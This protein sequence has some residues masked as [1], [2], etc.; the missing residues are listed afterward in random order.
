MDK[1]F[2]IILGILMGLLILTVN[3]FNFYSTE[4]QS[5]ENQSEENQS[6]KRNNNAVNFLRKCGISKR[7][8]KRMKGM[9]GKGLRSLSHPTGTTKQEILNCFDTNFFYMV[10]HNLCYEMNNN[11]ESEFNDNEQF[12]RIF[13]HKTSYGIMNA[14]SKNKRLW[15]IMVSYNFPNMINYL[16]YYSKSKMELNTDM[17]MGQYLT[18]QE[19]KVNTQSFW[20]DEY[21]KYKDMDL[22]LYHKE[23]Q[24]CSDKD[25]DF[26][27]FFYRYLLIKILESMK[28]NLSSR[29]NKDAVSFYMQRENTFNVTSMIL[30][31]NKN[32]EL[33]RMATYYRLP[34]VC[35]VWVIYNLYKNSINMSVD[36]DLGKA[37]LTEKQKTL[38]GKFD[39]DYVEFYVDRYANGDAE[40]VFNNID[41]WKELD[42]NKF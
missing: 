31:F 6:E 14:A 5:E 3:F 41:N 24:K 17:D 22:N 27:I 16:L 32:P 33:W 39:V 23:T 37:P 29:E 12:D 30:E 34:T 38:L 35:A 13:N 11:I 4:N 21:E 28:S 42:E 20:K 26:F 10:V 9:K 15:N 18:S 8:T 7:N 2:I 19:S 1:T 40:K 25:A 36:G